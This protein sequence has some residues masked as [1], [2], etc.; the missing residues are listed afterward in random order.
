MRRFCMIVLVGFAI[1]GISGVGAAAK[2]EWKPI[3]IEKKDLKVEVSAP[4]EVRQTGE[5]DD[6]DDTTSYEYRTTTGEKG[7]LVLTKPFGI[8]EKMKKSKYYLD[9]WSEAERQGFLGAM[10]QGSNSSESDYQF[11]TLKNGHRVGL[12]KVDYGGLQ[13]EQ[14]VFISSPYVV[15]LMVAGNREEVDEKYLKRSWDSV[16]F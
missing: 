7:M 5:A 2:S 15:L 9:D 11:V 3:L 1:M 14:I 13:G 6:G 16:K 8:P 10:N 12:K 4:E